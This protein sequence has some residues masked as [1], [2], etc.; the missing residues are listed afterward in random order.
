VVLPERSPLA[1]PAN[2]TCP[3]AEVIPPSGP[4]P[5]LTAT[6][7][8]V[9]DATTTGDP[10]TPSCQPDVSRS[11][12]YRFA[13]ETTADYTFSACSNAPTDTTLDDTVI[14]VYGSTPDGD[15]G[16]SLFQVPATPPFASCDDDSCVNEDF[17][18]ELTVQLESGTTYFVVVWQFGQT[19]PTAGNEAVQLRVTQ[20]NPLPPPPPND[21]CDGA[22]VIPGNG[23][24]PHLT[25]LLADVRGAKVTGD[26]PGPSCAPIVSNS[27][28]YA[29]TPSESADYTFATCADAPTGTT[30]EDTVV[31]VY[32]SDDDT[33]GGN[34][35]QLVDACDDDG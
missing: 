28:W 13:P 33:C 6:V 7:A 30:L 14:A 32:E 1:P 20:E 9:T 3:G 19:P 25:S 23:P 11:I 27:V 16:G 4:F 22:E 8:D 31:A 29:I 12:W 17:Q 21:T 15:C 35:A 18:S 34:L 5:H 26:P 2:D 24:F 10:P